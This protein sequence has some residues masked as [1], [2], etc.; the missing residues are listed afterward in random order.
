MPPKVLEPRR[1]QF[2]VAHR[3]L[4]VAVAEISL[5]CT[6]VVALVGQRI[7]ASVP[8]HVRVRLEGQL[9]LPARPFDN[10]GE[11]SRTKRC[12][13]FRGEHEGRLGFLLA[14]KPPQRPQFVSEDRMGAWGALLDPADVQGGGGELHLIPAQVHQFGDTQAV[15]E[16]H[17]N[18]HGVAV[19]PA[20][21]LGRFHQP[22]DLGLGQI[23]AGPQVGVSRTLGG[24]CSVYGG[25]RDQLEVRLGHVV[26]PSVAD[27]CSY[28]TSST[29]CRVEQR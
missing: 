5:Q 18:H 1:G 22:L 26:C 4:N 12:P 20:V 25:W 17:E 19:A 28:K 2:S 13:A 27:D 6:G 16:S 11:A 3:V 9:G 21:A 7:P 23:L 14:L 24:D 29:N 8:K 15:P 10:A